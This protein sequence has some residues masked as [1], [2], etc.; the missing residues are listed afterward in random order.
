MGIEQVKFKLNS[1]YSYLA[2]GGIR[3]YD[4]HSNLINPGNLISSTGTVTE[5]DNFII[6]SSSSTNNSYYE[7]FFA[8]DINKPLIGSYTEGVYWLTSTTT[9]VEIV[10]KFKNPIP[11]LTRVVYTPIPDPANGNRGI[12]SMSLEI[13]RE[14]GSVRTQNI[15]IMS[16]KNTSNSFYNNDSGKWNGI[17]GKEGVAG[18]LNSGMLKGKLIKPLLGNTPKFG[19][20]RGNH[21][22][23]S[24][25]NGSVNNTLEGRFVYK[26]FKGT[27]MIYIW[28]GIEYNVGSN[29]EVLN[30]RN[31]PTQWHPLHVNRDNSQADPVKPYDNLKPNWG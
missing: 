7:M 21:S 15:N 14:D 1:S 28:K 3:F 27:P 20:L 10:V 16:A 5:T 29:R 11:S 6:T 9:N 4:E 13:K 24:L 8:F 30:Y 2:I 25:Y 23:E 22:S 12:N 26:P 19:L 18:R 17:S 31:E